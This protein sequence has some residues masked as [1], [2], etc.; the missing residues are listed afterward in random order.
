MRTKQSLG[1]KPLPD[2]ST[3]SCLPFSFFQAK[4]SI[5]TSFYPS[6]CDHTKIKTPIKRGKQGYLTKHI[7]S[8][9][10]IQE[11]VITRGGGYSIYPWMGRCGAAPHYLTLFKTNIADFPTLF[12]TEFRFFNTLFKTFNPNI[13]QQKLVKTLLFIIQEKTSCLI[14]KLINRYPDKDKKMINSIPCL[15]QKSRKTYP[16]WPHVPIKP[17]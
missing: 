8:I 14:Q 12:K 2:T 5:H 16:G 9:L 3:A 4:P 7:N 1:I 17:L 11:Q 10:F 13:N 15:R 6:P